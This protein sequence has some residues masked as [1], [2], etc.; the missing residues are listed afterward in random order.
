M[1][2]E[3]P[4]DCLKIQYLM[5]QIIPFVLCQYKGP[6]GDKLD[7][8]GVYSTISK[9]IGDE[10]HDCTPTQTLKGLLSLMLQYFHPFFNP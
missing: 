3:L 6:L 8:F 7:I 5:T 2:G 4:I 1:L 9:C 10:I